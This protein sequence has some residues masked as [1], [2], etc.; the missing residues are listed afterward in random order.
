MHTLV[1]NATFALVVDGLFAGNL[2]V[3]LDSFVCLTSWF[4][5]C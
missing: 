2:V 4:V 5:D 3:T 1:V